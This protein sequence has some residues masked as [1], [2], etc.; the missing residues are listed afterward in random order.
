MST[1]LI[2]SGVVALV[3]AYGAI[4]LYYGVKKFPM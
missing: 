3:Y 2:I 4:S 1:I